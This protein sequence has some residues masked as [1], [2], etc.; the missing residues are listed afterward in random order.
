MRP[1]ERFAGRFRDGRAPARVFAIAGSRG[2]HGT[3]TICASI[4][5]A[6]SNSAP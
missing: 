5:G 1:G 2:D 3:T 4:R 6:A